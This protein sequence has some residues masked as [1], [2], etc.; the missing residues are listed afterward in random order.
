MP[1]HS[2][3]APA[4]ARLG[5]YLTPGL[6]IFSVAVLAAGWFFSPGF[7]TLFNAWQTP[8]Y[9]HGPLIPVISFTLFLR[10][11]RDVPVREGPIPLRWPGVLV[12]AMAV[13]MGT[14][15]R[16]AN[17]GDIVAY[18]LI[19]W[20]GG[21][22]LISLGWAQGWKFWPSILHL[23][24]MLPLPGVLYYKLSA[25]LQLVSSELGVSILRSF[26]VSVFLSGNIIDLG[27][28]QLHVAEACSGLR[29]LFPILSFS[30]VFAILYTGPKWHKAV[31]L[32]AAAPITVVMNSVRIA[33][34]GTIVQYWGVSYV[35][36]F[37]HF[38]EGWVIFIA[39][40]VILFILARILMLLHSPK[41]GLKKE[42]LDLDM[43]GC[44]PQLRRIRFIWPSTAMILAALLPLAAA[45]AF[46]AMP[47]RGVREIDRTPFALFPRQIGEWSSGIPT[48]LDASVERTLGADDYYGVDLAR[49][50]DE[51]TVNFFS[52]WYADQSRGGVHSP[53]ICLPG[54]GWEIAGLQRIDIAGKIG[55][56]EPFNINR[57]VI[58][59]GMVRQLVYYWF[60]QK[61]RKVAWDFAAKAYLV[62]DG[63]RTGR[64]DGALVRL[65]TVIS[66]DETEA[67]A[68]ERLLSVLTA[69]APVLP[70]FIPVAD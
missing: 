59:K 23:V 37:T 62:I 54:A 28:L 13:A 65:T 39:S 14:L 55:W 43:V 21:V 24:Y 12:V 50:E 60:D 15:G 64:T 30:Y 44:L 16:L 5:V 49:P 61:G 1:H 6:I 69:V 36:G 33:I 2:H 52:A 51:H 27:D 29:Y 48:V 3:A 7:T 19:L 38:F 41:D 17:I 47:E 46:A 25:F 70:E 4:P 9:S 53:E 45:L 58:Q 63:V 32:L 57:A 11:L 67:Q 34:A 40:V 8:E 42:A 22:L 35:E 20:T 18:S 26:G 31:L 56:P 10:H 66:S 68:E